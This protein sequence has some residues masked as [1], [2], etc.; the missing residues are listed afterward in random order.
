MNLCPVF[1]KQANIDVYLTLDK[2]L[3]LEMMTLI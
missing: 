1:W 3:L 2:Q